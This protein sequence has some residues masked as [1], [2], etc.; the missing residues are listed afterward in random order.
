[1]SG[2]FIHHDSPDEWLVVLTD[3]DGDR[4]D[5]EVFSG[6]YDIETIRERAISL[7]RPEKG[8]TMRFHPI[9]PERMDLALGFA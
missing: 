5:S 2:K 3:A 9:G 7:W 8:Y 4:T 6:E 1:M